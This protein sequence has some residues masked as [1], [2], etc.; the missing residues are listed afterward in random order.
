MHAT[1][2]THLPSG[3]GN[4]EEQALAEQHERHPLIVGVVLEVI[5]VILT[6]RPVLKMRQFVTNLF[7]NLHNRP[8]NKK[9]AFTFYFF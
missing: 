6:H 8:I 4:I 2:I 3:E 9:Q 5:G 1:R 7:N